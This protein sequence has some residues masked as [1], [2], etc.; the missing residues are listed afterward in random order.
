M[1]LLERETQLEELRRALASARVRQGR[2]V[3]DTVP[4]PRGV[5]FDLPGV[6]G[7]G[8]AR[9]DVVCGDFFHDRLPA[10]E[11]YLLMDILHDW[12][13]DDAIAILRRVRS[14]APAEARVFVIE[15]PSP[16]GVG[17]PWAHFMDIQM[18]ALLGGRQRRIDEHRA[19]LRQAGWQPDAVHRTEAEGLAI[20]E[21]VTN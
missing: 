17:P 11:A 21:A 2:T 15:V 20:I 18:L 10:C 14:A 8:S 5:L 6:A 19:L 3:L 4:S 7:E 12:P 16:D 1:P 9:L 13:D